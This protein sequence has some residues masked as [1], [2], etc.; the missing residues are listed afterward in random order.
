MEFFDLGS[1][2]AVRREH[3]PNGYSYGQNSNFR[4]DFDGHMMLPRDEPQRIRRSR[5]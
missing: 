5:Q 4:E 1:D 3:Y 2:P